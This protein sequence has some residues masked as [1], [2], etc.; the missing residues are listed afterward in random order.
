MEESRRIGGA[1][2]AAKAACPAVGGGKLGDDFK[3]LPITT[4]YLPCERLRRRRGGKQ[5][6]G[7]L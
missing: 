6:V 5:A 2:G 7:N 1:L 4:K 3:K